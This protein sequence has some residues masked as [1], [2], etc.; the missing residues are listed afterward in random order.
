MKKVFVLLIAAALFVGSISSAAF[1]EEAGVNDSEAVVIAWE[2]MED[3]VNESFDGGF[4]VFDDAGFKMWI[5]DVF[6]EVELTDED[7]EQG[8][9]GY[10][11]TEDNE[12]AIAV[13]INTESEL[14]LESYMEALEED[15][16]VSEVEVAVVNDIPCISYSNEDNDSGSIA[17]ELED[18]SLVEI[19]FA[20]ISDEGFAELVSI[21][22]ASVMADDEEA[23][24]AE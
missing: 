21:I 11:A 20:P 3:A 23:V 4:V 7:V 6:E 17:F 12:A 14:D 10:F 15:E 5:P 16:S 19:S 2:D 22:S 18:G 13:V 8:Y 24:D 1:A 9:I